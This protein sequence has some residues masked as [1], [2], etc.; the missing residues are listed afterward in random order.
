VDLADD[1]LS[2][3]L[4][5]R[6]GVAPTGMHPVGD[7]GCEGDEAALAALAAAPDDE[8]LYVVVESWE[9]PVGDQL[10]LLDAIR[11]HGGSARP[12]L[13]VLYG[14]G[15]DGN[16]AAPEP[17]HQQIWERAMRRRGDPRLFV[18]PLVS[19]MG[20]EPT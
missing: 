4:D 14:R 20:G 13:V 10:D 8:G 9:P 5:E 7:L 3:A 6:F 12:I 16:A 15:A 11:H 19:S 17:R 18:A 2:E 1:V